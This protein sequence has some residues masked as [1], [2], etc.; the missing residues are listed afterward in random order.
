MIIAVDIYFTN[1]MQCVA[2]VKATPK[3]D[4]K[5]SLSSSR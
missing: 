4:D 5:R 3:V 1:C 2:H